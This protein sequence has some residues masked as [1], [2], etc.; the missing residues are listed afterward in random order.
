MF[1]GVFIQG[2]GLLATEGFV[3]LPYHRKGVDSCAPVLAVTTHFFE[4]KG[5]ADG[6][7]YLAHQLEK[8]QVYEVIL[9]TGGGL[10]R[11]QLCDLVEVDQYYKLA[12]CLKFL[13]KGEMVSD[14][15][16]EKLHETHVQ[17]VI[18][19][20]FSRYSLYPTFCFLAPE[21]EDGSPRYVLYLEGVNKSV[22]LRAVLREIDQMLCEN[23]HYAYCRR[24]GQLAPLSG[25][26]LEPGSKELYIAQK[27]SQRRLGTLKVSCLE[28]STGWWKLLPGSSLTGA[29]KKG[30]TPHFTLS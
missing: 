15:C 18:E 4:F 14:L 9:T 13:G 5:V 12:P 6:K 26:V 19:K 28:R 2:K 24:L 21:V 22:A 29:L 3:T 30:S 25:Y 10:Y 17:G 7:I 1:P 20:C 23:F 11:Y 27:A 16:G 8:G